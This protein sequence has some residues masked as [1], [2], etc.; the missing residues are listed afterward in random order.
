MKNVIGVVILTGFW[1]LLNAQVP[2]E[3]TPFWVSGIS[4]NTRDIALG[5]IDGDGDLDMAVGNEVIGGINCTHIYFNTGAGLENYP[6]LVLPDS[7]GTFSVAFGDVDNDGDLDL[8]TAYVRG[9]GHRV[10]LYL[11]DGGTFDTIPD[12]VGTTGGIWCGWGDVDGDGDLDLATLELFFPASVYINNNGILESTPS[13]QAGEGFLMDFAGAWFDVDDDGDL[14]L[15]V[16]AKYRVYKNLGGTLETV[17]SWL[18][19]NP[20]TYA[21][22]GLAAGD[23]NHDGLL[24]LTVGCGADIADEVNRLHLNSLSGLPANPSW[25]SAD[26]AKTYRIALGDVD[27]DGGLDLAAANAGSAGQSDVVY[28]NTGSTLEMIPSWSSFPVEDSRGIAWAD[29]DNDGVISITDTLTGNGTRKLFY[30]SHFPAH[31]FQN[32]TVDGSPLPLSDYCYDPVAGW[33]SLKNAPANGSEILMDYSYSI[34][35]EL[36][37]GSPSPSAYR[38]TTIGIEEMPAIS[39][40]TSLFKITPIIFRKGSEISFILNKSGKVDLFLYDLLGREI[41]RKNMGKL[42]TGRH[43]LCTETKKLASGVYFVSVS[44][45]RDRQI[46]KILICE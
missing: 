17:A 32:V 30:L 19:N 34:D 45:G 7:N 22:T 14:D 43:T 13:W 10:T 27:A 20:S 31:I 37:V 15:A 5:D 25:T 40:P 38:N 35:L 6:S 46:E 41:L 28:R 36:V 18:G 16:G 26:A 3:T 39:V 21:G 33:V 24:D 12:W 8:A 42:Q 1:I 44:I 11:N 9:S 29:V 4:S 2:L 23:I